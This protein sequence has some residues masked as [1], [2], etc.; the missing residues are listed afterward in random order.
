MI[1]ICRSGGK[2]FQELWSNIIECENEGDYFSLRN[3]IEDCFA[4][5]E[6]S[7]SDRRI[8]VNSL[9]LYACFK[10]WETVGLKKFLDYQRKLR[11]VQKD[12]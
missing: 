7:T 1:R 2:K 5:D 10:G 6:I 9:D 11:E 3:H 8:L 12:V 4:D